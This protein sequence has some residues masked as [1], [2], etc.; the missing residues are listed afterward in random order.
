VYFAQLLNFMYIKLF[1]IVFL[2]LHYIDTTVI[3][4]KL[5][6]SFFLFVRQ[7]LPSIS[8]CFSTEIRMFLYSNLTK[9]RNLKKDSW[10]IK[11]NLSRNKY[12]CVPVKILRQGSKETVVHRINSGHVTREEADPS[13]SPSSTVDI[14]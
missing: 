2:I 12:D 9:T 14:E 8:L 6:I 5:I 7:M 13:S 11:K 10:L 4:L 1:N 3:F